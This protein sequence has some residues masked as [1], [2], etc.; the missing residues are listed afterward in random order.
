MMES[1]RAEK[2]RASNVVRVGIVGTGFGRYGHLP[3]FRRDARCEVV[4]LA[5][6]SRDRVEAFA[7]RLRVPQAFGDWRALIDNGSLDALAVATSPADQK[8]IAEAALRRGIAV[9][10]E[11]PLAANL[12]H[13][14]E[15][16]RLADT[17]GCANVVNFIFPE[18]TSW[19][20][21]KKLLDDGAVGSLRHVAVDWRMEGHSQRERVVNWKTNVSE[22]GGVL[23]H[24]GSHT[25]H[26]MEY[27]FGPVAELSATLTSASDLGSRAD[28]MATLC[29]QFDSGLSGAAYLCSAATQA[30]V[31]KIEIYG[32][33]GGL[34]LQN[35]SEDPVFGF[36]LKMASRDSPDHVLIATEAIGRNPAEDSRVEPVSRLAS[37]FLDWCIYGAP[38]APSFREGLRVQQ[39]IA[40]A[41]QSS[42]EKRTIEMTS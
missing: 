42:A 7:S 14:L 36:E 2:C 41:Q 6:R 34:V 12:E 9:F 11:K 15:L 25:L 20:L 19:R 40:A 38:T 33:D 16:A 17:S 37:R 1:R 24:F 13:A 39:L 3:A 10:A 22:G 28:T 27:L 5:A 30:S 4:A 23:Q 35:T 21:T 29:L 8:D 32:S 31:H 18:L 26:Y